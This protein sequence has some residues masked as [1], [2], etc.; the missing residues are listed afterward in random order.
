[1]KRMLSLA[2]GA[3]SL[4]S[5]GGCL[6]MMGMML[7]EGHGKS[8]EKPADKPKGEGEETPRDTGLDVSPPKG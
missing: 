3:V 6:P 4:A 8:H 5:L 2:V 7:M 1:M